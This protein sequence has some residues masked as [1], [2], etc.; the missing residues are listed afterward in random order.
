MISS[1][2]SQV[3]NSYQVCY[4]SEKNI[5]DLIKK[6][7]P[8]I[9]FLVDSFAFQKKG[10]IALYYKGD[11]VGFLDPKDRD[12]SLAIDDYV[13]KAKYFM[14]QDLDRLENAD[15]SL[16]RELK[17]SVAFTLDKN[18]RGSALYRGS[19]TAKDPRVA[20]AFSYIY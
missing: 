19:P 15:H 12:L 1:N 3:Q 4:E 2:L 17:D 9:T 20:K 18:K 16:Y 11:C 5:G 14:S 6:K 8:D 10:S 13:R 7:L